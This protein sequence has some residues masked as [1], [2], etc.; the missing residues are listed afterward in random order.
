MMGIVR[1]LMP[2]YSSAR[3]QGRWDTVWC[4]QPADSLK[5]PSRETDSAVL[6]GDLSSRERQ[7][8]TI[9]VP[10]LPRKYTTWDQKMVFLLPNLSLEKPQMRQPRTL[11]A[12]KVVWISVG[13][14]SC[15]PTQSF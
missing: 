10:R 14:Q 3:R 11:P 12:Q 6:I 4:E 15:S 8:G 1:W 2:Q 5:M 13:I 9:K 7:I